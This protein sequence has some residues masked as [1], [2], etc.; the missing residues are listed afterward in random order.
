LKWANLKSISLNGLWKNNPGT[1]Q[2]LGLCPLLAVSSTF[3][4][5]F[6]LGIATL[7]VLVCSNGLVSCFARYIPHYLRLPFFVLLIASFVTFT[8]IFLSV[9]YFNLYE[10]LGIYLALIT[11]NCVIMGR[12]E[13]FA[14]KNSLGP[15]LLDGLMNGLGFLIVLCLIGALREW[16]GQGF[17]LA[18]LP[19]GAFMILGFIIAITRWIALSGVPPRNDAS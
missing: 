9:Y 19:P 10:S 16:I 13:S 1:V 7:F 2:L 18:L 3:I 14:S 4:N 6:T 17:L 5:A 12:A 11:T 15:A 8:Q